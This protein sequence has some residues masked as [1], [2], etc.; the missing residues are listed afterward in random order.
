[1]L[2]ALTVAGG[3]RGVEYSAQTTS[4]M[5]RHGLPAPHSAPAGAALDGGD[6]V[7]QWRRRLAS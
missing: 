4:G 1:V 3:P 7:V 5:I 2:L 6:G